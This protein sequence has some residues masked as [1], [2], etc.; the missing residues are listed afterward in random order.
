MPSD[1]SP[2]WELTVSRA[3]G[4]ASGS[5]SAPRPSSQPSI[6]NGSAAR[7]GSGPRAEG[8][9]QP[10]DSGP[11]RRVIRSCSESAGCALPG[12]KRGLT[13]RAG[14][15]GNAVSSPGAGGCWEGLRPWEH[16]P[17]SSAATSARVSAPEPRRRRAL[18]SV[19]P[20]RAFR[21][22]VTVVLF[23]RGPRQG[24][25]NS[26]SATETGIEPSAWT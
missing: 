14:C 12:M 11:P 9:S 20:A 13:E 5:I 18:G 22:A 25:G 19:R 3:S 21:G 15:G 23:F 4:G 10:S 1:F 17:A 7:E 16:A 2:G 8:C 24:V 26:T 6:P